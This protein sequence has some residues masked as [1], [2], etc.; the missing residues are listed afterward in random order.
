MVV[1]W[2]AET[3]EGAKVVAV[4][5]EV[6]AEEVRVVVATGVVTVV[7]ARAEGAMVAAATAVVTE[8]PMLRHLWRARGRC[9]PSR[10]G[11]TCRQP[12]SSPWPSHPSSPRPA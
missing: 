8:A 5:A 10:R 7:A 3:E 2:V 1:V 9:L 4:M 12:P 11:C 6:K